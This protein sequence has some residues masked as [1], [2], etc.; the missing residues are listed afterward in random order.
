MVNTGHTVFWTEANGCSVFAELS[1]DLA[2]LPFSAALRRHPW[3]YIRFLPSAMTSGSTALRSWI[4]T[5]SASATLQSSRVFVLHSFKEAGRMPLIQS[6][7]HIQLW[8]HSKW[9]FD[10]ADF[11]FNASLNVNSPD[12]NTAHGAHSAAANSTGNQLYA[13]LMLGYGSF[14]HPWEGTSQAVI[15][16][17][18]VLTAAVTSPRFLQSC[19]SVV[20]ATF[21][22]YRYR[23]H[24]PCCK[25]ALNTT[26]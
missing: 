8:Q 20:Y 26:G 15:V 19:S 7:Y 2:L 16:T 11:S 13:S 24:M 4:H 22:R 9:L 1:V 23:Y 6:T 10:C 5:A 14:A 21:R 12:S 3:S 25:S 18:V 17:Q